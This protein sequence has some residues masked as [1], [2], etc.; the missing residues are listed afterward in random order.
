M[1]LFVSSR[2]SIIQILLDQ[3]SHDELQILGCQTLFDFVN[4][5]RDG[6]YMFNLDEFI[7]KLGH[8]AQKMG[9]VLE[10][11]G[12]Q[13]NAMRLHSWKVIVNDEEKFDVPIEDAMNPRFWSRLIEAS[14]LASLPPKGSHKDV[15]L[16]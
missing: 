4:N 2:L 9:V 15:P 10:I 8:L 12:C 14:P 3:T 1:P 7:S 11:W 13:E 16:L 6:T 5:Q